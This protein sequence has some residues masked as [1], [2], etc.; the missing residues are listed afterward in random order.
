[1]AEK[2]GA[3]QVA[4]VMYDYGQDKFFLKDDDGLVNPIVTAVTD[5]DTGRVRLSGLAARGSVL[6]AFVGDSIT[7]D[8]PVGQYGAREYGTHALELSSGG[9]IPCGK[10]GQGGMGLLVPGN[11]GQTWAQTIEQIASAS[12][13]PERAHLLIG[14]NDLGAGVAVMDLIAA[15]QVAVKQLESLGIE[16]VTSELCPRNDAISGA[17]A[18]ALHSFNIWVNRWSRD[19]GRRCQHFYSAC[20]DRAGTGLWSSGYNRDSVHPGVVGARVMGQIAVNA[21]S[22]D[23]KHIPYLVATSTD[24]TAFGNGLFLTDSITNGSSAQTA[25]DGIPDGWGKANTFSAEFSHSIRSAGTAAIGNWYTQARTAAATG[26]PLLRSTKIAA[27]NDDLIQIGFVLQCN[28]V[29]ANIRLAQSAGTSWVDATTGGTVSP[30]QM[31]TGQ[32]YDANASYLFEGRASGA[33]VASVCAEISTIAGGDAGDV[34]I[35]QFTIRNL[36]ALGLD[37]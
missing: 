26:S 25:G 23:Y 8:V 37:F 14:T 15:Y 17:L 31:I 1:M 19:S 9:M 22:S 11:S 4:P 3:G 6:T 24:A 30:V 12:P 16:V 28:A 2:I 5:P 35:A 18:L 36:T 33:T 27:S 20:V 10:Y 34:K 32:V 13:R 21:A 29:G 7:N